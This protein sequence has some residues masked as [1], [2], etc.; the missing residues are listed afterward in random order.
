MATALGQYANIGALKLR[1]GAADSIDDAL[2]QS[3]CDQANMWIETKTGRILAPLAAFSTTVATGF[4]AGTNT[5]TLTS[6]S[7]L[8]VNDVLMFGPVSG[9]HESA[10]V[11]AIS[12]TTVTLAT[13]LVSGYAGANVKRVFVFDGFNAL[14]GGKLLPL[15][16][17]VT[18]VSTLEVCTFS[19]GQGGATTTNVTW[20]TVP[21]SDWFLRPVPSERQPGQPATELWI[22]NVPVP[23]DI[24]PSFYPGVNNVRID[25]AFGWPVIPDDIVEVA[26]NIAVGLYRARSSVGGE[27]VNLGTDGGHVVQ[28]ALSY[29]NRQTIQRYTR[30]DIYVV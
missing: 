18:S 5:G 23:S 20:Y 30:H 27:V 11:S 26:L 29:E 1:L 21:A 4:T 25:G 13:N 22:T 24:T 12:G 14:E 15:P 28:R 10:A 7:G 2:L 16:L 17:G 6:A 8:A 19:A 9:T 3:F